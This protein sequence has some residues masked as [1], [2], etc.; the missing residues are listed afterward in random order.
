M[1]RPMLWLVHPGCVYSEMKM[2]LAP[3]FKGCSDE[4]YAEEAHAVLDFFRTH[5]E[6]MLT[7]LGTE[8]DAASAAM[9]FEQAA[10]LHAQIVKV[11]AAA[12][13]SDEIVRPLDQLDAVILQ[14]AASAEPSV[15]ISAVG[16]CDE[17]AIF[18][19][20]HGC[21]TPSRPVL[22][23]TLGMRHA[24]EDSGSTS[25]FAQ[26]H[27]LAAVPLD[28]AGE[29]ALAAPIETTEE[30]LKRTL[31]ELFPA[32]K[33]PEAEQMAG[34]SDHISL[35]RRWYYRPSKQ[36]VGEIFFRTAAS[37][38]AGLPVR[39]I[40]RGISRVCVKTIPTAVPAKI[41]QDSAE[42]STVD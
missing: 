6:S 41:T 19:V 34:L 18:A 15:G 32:G 3:C 39:R 23:S 38:D 33:K 40:L 1:V 42:D 10:A 28:D 36:R 9:E 35:L 30:R 21:I 20:T 27:M 13:C 24:N 7:K 37:A 11:K 22:F 2:C 17:V 25:L 8:R 31:L 12:Q 26:P 14:P 4:R 16:T 29:P 5:G